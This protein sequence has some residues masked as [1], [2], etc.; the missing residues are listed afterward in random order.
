[1]RP[2]QAERRTH[3]YTRHGTLT[4]LAALDAV[5]GKIIGRCYPCHRARYYLKFLRE[6]ERNV[7]ADLGISLITDNYATHKTPP[8]RQW[9]T[10]RP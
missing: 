7:L 10:S 5:T 1:M 9:L 2:G 4:L 3:D 6:I 8:I